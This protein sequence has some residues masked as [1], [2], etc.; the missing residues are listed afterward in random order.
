[1]AFVWHGILV[2]EQ[3]NMHDA[4]YIELCGS[5]KFIS[6]PVFLEQKNLGSVSVIFKKEEQYKCINSFMYVSKFIT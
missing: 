1:M 3:K 4:N 5:K 2:A 6:V